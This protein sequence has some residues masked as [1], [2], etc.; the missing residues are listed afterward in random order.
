MAK[1]RRPSR[2]RKR[3]TTR[4]ARVSKAVSKPKQTPRARRIRKERRALSSNPNYVHWIAGFQE[5]EAQRT[6]KL[7][8]VNSVVK[9]P[10]FRKWVDV[11]LGHDPKRK[12]GPNSQLAKALVELGVRDP[13]F[14]GAVGNSPGRGERVQRQRARGSSRNER[15]GFRRGQ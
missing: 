14:K 2:A 7:P 4:G 11:I 6:G 13:T 1:S 8:S 12:H 15:R 3:A 10:K 9:N 5:R